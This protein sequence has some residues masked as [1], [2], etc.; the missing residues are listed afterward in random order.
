MESFEGFLV[1]AWLSTKL[2]TESVDIIGGNGQSERVHH[3]RF[4]RH[5]DRVPSEPDEV[6]VSDAEA[7]VAAAPP[8]SFAAGAAVIEGYLKTMPSSPGVYRMLDKNGGVLYVGKAKN[9]KK[10]V[11]AYTKPERIPIRI[12]QIG[13]AHV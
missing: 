5:Y 2:S 1:G 7:A 10:R 4:T 9:L 8:G 11:T 13:R 6:A 12:Q 3:S